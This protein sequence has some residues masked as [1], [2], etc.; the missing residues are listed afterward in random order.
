[1]LAYVYGKNRVNSIIIHIYLSPKKSWWTPNSSERGGH[2]PPTNFPHSSCGGLHTYCPRLV[3][4]HNIWTGSKT[5]S[6]IYIL[7]SGYQLTNFPGSAATDRPAT[8]DN[9]YTTQILP[10]IPLHVDTHAHVIPL[11]DS[12]IM[13]THV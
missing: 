11:T 7:V 13:Y 2:P 4:L 3:T 5:E 8:D 12:H 1:M 6:I 9:N 10:G